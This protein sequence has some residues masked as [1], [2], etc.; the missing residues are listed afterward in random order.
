MDLYRL[1]KS[2]L[3]GFAEWY[4]WSL[5]VAN[6]KS[7][8]R[9]IQSPSCSRK[10]SGGESMLVMSLELSRV[11]QEQEWGQLIAQTAQGDQAALATFYDRT[12]SQVFGL[13]YKILNNR[14][15][16]EEVT[17]DV[18]TQ[19]WRQAHTYDA[20]RGRPGAWLM[21]LARTRAID[22]FRA[23]AAE[24][25]RMESL[26]AADLFASDGDTPEQDVES[27]ERRRYVQQALATLTAEQRQA[28]ALAYFYGMS[29]SEI[30]E[31]LD[32]PLGTV[33][34]RIRLGMIKLREALAP[35]EAGLLS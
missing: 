13:V 19:V 4:S 25:G 28:V 16:A 5:K 22:R 33:K 14:E 18:Y 8:P 17:L 1:D 26:D 3:P 15:A 9:E 23:G 11:I 12:S 34:T 10:E 27:Q 35:Y 20:T 32:L 31:K 21:T 29:Q 6:G 24:Y 30:A 2:L 7:V